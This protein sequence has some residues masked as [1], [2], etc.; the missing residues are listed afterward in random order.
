MSG[1]NEVIFDMSFYLGT[2]WADVPEV[3][4]ESLMDQ[5]QGSR[6]LFDWV[7]EEATAFEAVWIALDEQDPRREDYYGEVDEWFR[8]AFAKLIL[9]GMNN[10]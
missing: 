5:L 10:G 1:I 8:T 7:H 3:V 9:G 6:G 2:Q 4:R